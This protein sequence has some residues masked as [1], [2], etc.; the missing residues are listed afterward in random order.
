MRAARVNP[1]KSFVRW[2][3]WSSEKQILSAASRE[4]HCAGDLLGMIPTPPG[5]Y[6]RRFNPPS[7]LVSEGA[8]HDE[9]STDDRDIQKHTAACSCCT[10][11]AT[12]SHP[13]T[14][15]QASRRGPHHRPAA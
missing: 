13:G 9:E 12:R 4:R 1:I 2:C 15:R 11:S 3:G 10:S 14:A 6:L 5:I 8:T 7:H